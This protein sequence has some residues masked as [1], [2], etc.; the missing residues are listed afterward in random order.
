[1]IMIEGHTDSDAIRAGWTSN[2]E[3]GAARALAVLHF[4]TKECGIDGARL[5]A[6]TY[7][8]YRPVAGNATEAE[9]SKNRRAVVV[10]V[11]E[12]KVTRVDLAK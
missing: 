7:S 5:S 1:M 4:M 8:H 3:L 11:P 6:I 12:M 10:I 9:R 2:W